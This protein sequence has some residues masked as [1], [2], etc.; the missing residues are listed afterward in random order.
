M[1]KANLLLDIADLA[2]LNARNNA[3]IA[4]TNM[5]SAYEKAQDEGD[6]VFYHPD[7]WTFTASWNETFAEIFEDYETARTHLPWINPDNFRLLFD[8]AFSLSTTTGKAVSL[9]TLNEEFANE[10]N[11]ILCCTEIEQTRYV[12]NVHS[13]RELHC[14]YVTQHN[15]W[16]DWSKNGILFNTKFS[17]LCIVEIVDRHQQEFKE[18]QKLH[19]KQEK[20]NY[21]NTDLIRILRSDKDRLLQLSREIARRNGYI[22]DAKLS[23]SEKNRRKTR[24][25]AIFKI[26]RNNEWQ[27]LSLDTENGQFEVCNRKGEHI[28]VWNF[29]GNKT[30]NADESGGH[31]IKL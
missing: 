3:N 4:L 13:W 27:Y 25:S 8:I 12:Y 2:T 31:D 5:F 17:D 1:R 14:S 15:E 9:D 28:G 23:K 11:G 7:F 10:N 30:A 6:K 26:K 20:I 18:S 29:S 24:M 21:F 16:I 22:Y 19:K